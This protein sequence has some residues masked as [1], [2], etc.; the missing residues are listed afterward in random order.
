MHSG[1]A[2]KTLHHQN[3]FTQRN[4]RR[5]DMSGGHY[6]YAYEK[7]LR[8]VE[9]MERDG[10]NNTSDRRALCTHLRLCAEAMR[11]VEW[12]DSGDGADENQKIE[13]VFMHGWK[14]SS[15]YL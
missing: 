12:E 6:D 3:G 9:K 11:A 8:F 14:E 5:R 1:P 13:D 4:G 2:S 15:N 10:K 7:V